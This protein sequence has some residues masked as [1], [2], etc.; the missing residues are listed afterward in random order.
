MSQTR[1]R[2]WFVTGFLLLTVVLHFLLGISD[3]ITQEAELL[4]VAPNIPLWHIKL[5][6]FRSLGVMGCAI[7]L[8][9]LSHLQ[10]EAKRRDVQ[11]D[12]LSA[13][14]GVPG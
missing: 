6:G 9:N 4:T 3:L 11:E 12:D 13:M 8:Q 2:Y 10:H 7:A 5:S 14:R 1:K